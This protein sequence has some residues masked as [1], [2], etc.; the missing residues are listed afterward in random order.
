MN[1]TNAIKYSDWRQSHTQRIFQFDFRI[2]TEPQK[3]AIRLLTMVVVNMN[4]FDSGNK[5]GH[6]PFQVKFNDRLSHEIDAN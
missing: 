6:K 4:W 2:D 1:S 5:F 3:N